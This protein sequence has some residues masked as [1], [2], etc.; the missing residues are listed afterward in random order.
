[1][2]QKK[3]QQLQAQVARP[4]T[5][6]VPPVFRPQS[7]ARPLQAK[8]IATVP[9]VPLAFQPHAGRTVQARM[10]LPVQAQARPSWPGR[11]AIVQRFALPSGRT[12]PDDKLMDN[13]FLYEEYKL[14]KADARAGDLAAIMAL[15]TT[16]GAA[17]K[18][19]NS[20]IM[21]MATPLENLQEYIE[22]VPDGTYTKAAIRAALAAVEGGAA[23]SDGE[24]ILQ[25]YALLNTKA[26]SEN[27]IAPL[28]QLLKSGAI[29]SNT[30]AYRKPTGRN[31]SATVATGYAHHFYY[32]GSA[33]AAYVSDISPEVHYHENWDNPALK[34]YS[35][36]KLSREASGAFA[37]GGVNL[38][39]IKEALK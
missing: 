34:P 37:L 6:T 15:Q 16:A 33:K 2:S 3:P 38:Q 36:R 29:I 32:L 11:P 24:L 35:K 17:T 22:S 28:C 27:M 31:G 13:P 18:G 5:P 4:Q 21:I 9:R 39:K 20:A 12:I 1:M 8:A 7:N 14:A 19:Q 10:A 26:V 23:K 25:H 30:P